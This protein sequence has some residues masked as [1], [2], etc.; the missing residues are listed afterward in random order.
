MTI[1]ESVSSCF[2]N[3]ACFV[4]R[5]RRSEYWYFILFTSIIDIILNA[6]ASAA[7]SS[8][9]SFL[10]TVWEIAV[11]L[12]TLAVTW[13]RLHDVGRS[14]AWALLGAAFDVFAVVMSWV[15]AGSLFISLITTAFES[16]FGLTLFFLF[17]AVA[18]GILSIVVLVWLCRYSEPGFNRFGPSPKYPAAPGGFGGEQN[19]Y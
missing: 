4:G 14:G 13:R 16:F 6:A 1:W 3:Y 19:W 7:D 18:V 8:F 11:F 12:P 2:R 10:G 5:A 9:F 17:V 15:L